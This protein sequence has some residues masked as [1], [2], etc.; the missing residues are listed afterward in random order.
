MSY[1]ILTLNNISVRGL[2]RL[3][4]ER[5]EVA[6]EIGHPD[7]ILVR[8]ADMHAVEIPASVKAIGRAGAGTN[9][10]PVAAL[11]K[12]GVP[13]FNAPGANAN[14]VKELVLASMFLAARNLVASRWLRFIVRRLMEEEG[15]PGDY[16]LFALIGAVAG[17]THF[18]ATLWFASLG[19][20]VGLAQLRR[21]SV[22]RFLLW[23]GVS[24]IAAAPAVAWI[25]FARPDQSPSTGGPP[26]LSV[27]AA[28]EAARALAATHQK[29]D[30]LP[31]ATPN[32]P[33]ISSRV[34]EA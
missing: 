17:V 26:L 27:A 19:A 4:R 11:S 24:L 33:A 32:D 31:A 7:A 34:S 16:A 18:F 12:R 20:C 15:G 22:G 3:P 23:A 10:I 21:G 9:N 6:S 2:E 25:A 14:A 29:R 13:V 28:T 5:F 30:Q 8:S 1:R